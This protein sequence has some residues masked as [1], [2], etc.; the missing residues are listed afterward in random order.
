MEVADRN[1]FY[2]PVLVSK[3]IYHG[4]LIFRG[5]QQMEGGGA[6]I[7]RSLSWLSWKDPTSV[8]LPRIDRKPTGEFSR[9][10]KKRLFE[11]KIHGQVFPWWNLGCSCVACYLRDC[12]NCPGDGDKRSNWMRLNQCFFFFSLLV[13]VLFEDEALWKLILS[14][15]PLCQP[16][17]S[18]ANDSLG[19]FCFVRR[20][21]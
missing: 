11:M 10:E 12:F 3:G 1:M 17:S 14:Q 5:L 13:R 21:I 19:A 7:T 18:V 2:F 8:S 20:S 4:C 15:I 9:L 16:P 6:S